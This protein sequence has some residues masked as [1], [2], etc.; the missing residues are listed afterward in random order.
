M[1]NKNGLSQLQ[2]S[3]FSK[4]FT[5]LTLKLGCATILAM[6]ASN[7][8]SASFNCQNAAQTD[9]KIVCGSV[10]LSTLDEQLSKRYK[11]AIANNQ[12]QP[13][14]KLEIQRSQ[15][16][17]L[18]Q[19][20][21]CHFSFD[22]IK[23]VYR[24]RISSLIALSRTESAFSWGGNYRL[25]PS[26]S[27]TRLGSARERQPIKVLSQTDVMLNGYPWF[28]IEIDGQKAYQWGGIICDPHF[29]NTT[30]CE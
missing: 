30:F 23:R 13:A 17:W 28:Q 18:S 12:A 11:V 10:E 5:L 29:P 14:K 26:T 2:E 16:Q 4:I 20:K 6:M 27:A 9:E 1:N 7:A 15:T 25:T 22:C 3:T 21:A 8:F 19:R 24:K